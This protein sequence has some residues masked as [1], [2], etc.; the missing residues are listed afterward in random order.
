MKSGTKD[1][2][3]KAAGVGTGKV[4]MLGRGLLSRRVNYIL[5]VGI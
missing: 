1:S 3:D 5:P 4:I 2:I